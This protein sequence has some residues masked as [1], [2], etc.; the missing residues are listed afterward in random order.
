MTVLSSDLLPPQNRTVPTAAV[1]LLCFAAVAVVAAL[2][3]PVFPPTHPQ[4]HTAMWWILAAAGGALAL[5]VALRPSRS[6]SVK[7]GLGWL[8]LILALAQA[9]LIGDM[10]AMFG[11]W[12]VVP[13]LAL[14][15]GKL[16]PK[17]RKALVAAHVVAAAMWVGIAVTFVAMAVVAVSSQDVTTGTATYE[18]MAV[19]D[20]T[21]LPWANFA[22]VLTG[23]ALS[24]GTK[25]GLLSYYWVMAKIVISVG[26]LVAAFTFLHDAL[27]RAA[28]EAGVSGGEQVVLRGFGFASLAL[29]A[30][31]LLSLYKPG[32][33]TRFATS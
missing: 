10:V 3:P 14:M 30:A 13:A 33:R 2:L 20:V 7:L 28:S 26:I 23:L 16:R 15:A 19:F 29:V 24:L 1:M 8:V 31:V 32:G 22:T 11:T 9:F 4:A 5:I 27:E 6:R 25:W 18:L 12:L 17:P 21:L